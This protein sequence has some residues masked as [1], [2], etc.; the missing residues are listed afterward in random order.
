MNKEYI[1]HYDD[2]EL[3]FERFFNRFLAETRV[4][5]L[6]TNGFISAIILEDLDESS[7]Y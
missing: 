6:W 2:G 3:H 1:V 4:S 5:E 7:L